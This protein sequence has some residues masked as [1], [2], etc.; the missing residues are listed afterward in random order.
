LS[1]IDQK[2]TETDLMGL[3]TQVPADNQFNL[4]TK[5]KSRRK[6]DLRQA[7]KPKEMSG[8]D[9]TVRNRTDKRGIYVQDKAPYLK[10]FPL[11]FTLDWNLTLEELI[12]T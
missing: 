6:K 5:S 10:V 12:L 3:I 4:P 11:L 7:L 8:S 1:D 2:G 9:N